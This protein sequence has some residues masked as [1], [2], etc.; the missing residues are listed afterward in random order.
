MGETLR[1]FFEPR[2]GR[3]LRHV[4]LHTGAMAESHSANFGAHAFTVGSHIWFGRGQAPDRSWLTAHE[5]A[6]VL[7]QTG[8]GGDPARIRRVP[9]GCPADPATPAV[10]DAVDFQIDSELNAVRQSIFEREPEVLREGDAGDAVVLIQDFLLNEICTGIDRTGLHAERNDARFGSITRKAVKRYQQT[11]TDAIGRPL[12][13]DG[14]VGPFTLGALDASLGLAV[15]PPAREP[16]GEGDCFGV[17]EQGPGEAERLLPGQ[18]P[19]F[20]DFHPNDVV[21]ELSNF[22]VAKHFVKTEHRAFLRD[23]VVDVINALPVADTRLRIIGEASTTAG[24]DFNQPLSERRAACVTTA[25][26]DAGLD[27][28]AR[29]ETVVGHGEELAQVRRFFEGKTPIDNVEDRKARK[30]SIVLA[31]RAVDEC[32]DAM[33]TRGSTQ[34]V[35]RVACESAFSVLLNIGDRSDPARPT[36]REFRW[37]H[38]PWPSGC[39]FHAGTPP[40]LPTLFTNFETP[41]EFHLARRDPN[42]IDAPSEFDGPA[43]HQSRVFSSILFG[44]KNKYE[45]PLDGFWIPPDCRIATTDTLGRLDPRGT[46]QCGDVPAPPQGDCALVEEEDCPDTYKVSKAQK[47][48]GVMFGGSA[49]VSR[50]LPPAWRSFV[51]L[52]AAGVVVSFATTDLPDRQLM[53][54]FVYIG[55]RIGGAG[56]GLD[57]LAAAGAPEK[58]VGSPVQLQNSASGFG[59]VL[60]NSDF[61]KLLAA[62][63]T[64]KGA[65]N[66]IELETG[67]A[68]FPFF[69]PHC[70]AGGTRNFYGVFRPVGPAFCVDEL[71]DISLPERSCEEEED[72]PEST[73]LAGHR[74]FRIRVG[75]LTTQG[76]PPRL[77][78]L[79]AKYGCELVAA[80]IGIDTD[81]ADGGPIHREFALLMRREDCA[82]TIARG[83][84]ELDVLLGRQLATENPDQ[85]DALSDFIGAATLDAG[86]ELTIIAATH[87]PVTLKLPG[88]YDSA[89][90]GKRAARGAVLP[91]SVVDCGESPEPDHDTRPEADHVAQCE[92]F[93]LSSAPLVDDAVADLKAN[94][95]DGVIAAIGAPPRIIAPPAVYEE[96]LRHHKPGD[97]VRNAFFVGK[98]PGATPFDVVRVVAF[99][100]FRILAVNT[101][102]T[103]VIEFVTDLCAFDEH[104]N[105]VALRPNG[106]AD[107]FARAGDVKRVGTIRFDVNPVQ[108]Q[109]KIA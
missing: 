71:P 79:G 43:T 61:R 69:G 39:T 49:D 21:W 70:N 94:S 46:V 8:P 38:M 20:P 92:A 84:V 109:G 57:R 53:R 31:T 80:E 68:T 93:K 91:T 37:V 58:D 32:S 16:E 88:S 13:D 7:Q 56:S 101:D 89:C 18:V 62:K 106:C 35:V 19:P 86:G 76:L 73:R 26:L 15:I 97:I 77:R 11:H 81:D 66:R 67:V 14:R 100:D 44:H 108:S 78:D 52:G 30:V 47:Y 99:A 40:P 85:F 96:W 29:I 42:R 63:L 54:F 72:C 51:P 50:V 90:K 12:S 5:L 102:K 60:G 33:K 1:R 28:P 3:D 23:N 104:G 105:V 82:F 36:Y 48:L 98:A 22:D 83:D 10:P 74:H 9:A 95:F 107:D 24:L 4:R 2:F 55:G 25:L 6:H 34:W 59:G 17:A 75:R 27:D 45:M 41:V 103:M 87:L 65:S 64:L